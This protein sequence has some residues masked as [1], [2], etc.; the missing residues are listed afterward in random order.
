MKAYRTIGERTGRGGDLT[1]TD[2]EKKTLILF[3]YL[4][5]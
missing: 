3:A 5:N 2:T 4:K 1:I